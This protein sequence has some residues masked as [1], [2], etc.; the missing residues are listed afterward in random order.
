MAA[1]TKV[2]VHVGLHGGGNQ[3]AQHHALATATRETRTGIARVGI[4]GL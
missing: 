2:H 3:G 4:R 1:V